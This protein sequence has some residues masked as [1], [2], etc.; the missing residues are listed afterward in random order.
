V[1]VREEGVT[2]SEA[3]RPRDAAAVAAADDD[4]DVART[5]CTDCDI[6][7]SSSLCC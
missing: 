2:G 1:Q 4:G 3:R 7:L 5:F 6:C